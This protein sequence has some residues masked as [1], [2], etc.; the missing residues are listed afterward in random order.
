MDFG[1]TAELA[2][3]IQHRHSDGT[4]GQLEPRSHHDSADHDPERG[5]SSGA[6]IYV[7]KTCD[8]EVM[9]EPLDDPGNPRS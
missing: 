5:W 3:R 7:C 1:R 6:T 8:E 2:L 4:W 9:V